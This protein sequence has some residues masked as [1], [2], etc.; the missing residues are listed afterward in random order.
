MR[1]L[2]IVT[3]LFSIFI[4]PACADKPAPIYGSYKSSIINW[5]SPEGIKRF[6]NSQYKKDYYQLAH[7]FQPQINPLYCGIASSVIVLNAMRL[8]Q[9]KVENQ[10]QIQIK[11]PE[12]WGG[13]FVPFKSYSQQT[14]LNSETDKVKKKEIIELKNIGSK[15]KEDLDP[16]LTLTQLSQ[17]LESYQ[18]NVSKHHAQG[19]NNLQ[20]FR[21]HLKKYLS[22][23]KHFI[24]ANFKGKI[25]GSQ[26]GG[27]ISPIAAYDEKSDSL[28]LLDVAGHKQPWHW[29]PVN[30]FYKGMNSLDGKQYRGWL[31]LKDTLSK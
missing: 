16:G 10:T 18:V 14:F 24:L 15:Q 1:T 9:G 17:I 3:I 28:L 31:I 23:D 6:E 27:H 7:M 19:E 22:E 2:S 12:V 25:M 8:P 20:I 29:V 11:K 30:L 21:S 26:T 13:G 5:Y 4:H